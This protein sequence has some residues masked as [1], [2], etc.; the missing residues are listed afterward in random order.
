M[1]IRHVLNLYLCF[2]ERNVQKS[3][4]LNDLERINRI[5]NYM[6][7]KMSSLRRNVRLVLVISKAHI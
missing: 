4:V 7:T 2:D 3:I 6:V 1:Y 5:Y